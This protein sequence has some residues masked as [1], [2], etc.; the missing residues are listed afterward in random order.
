M[1]EKTV[2]R[3]PEMIKSTK[4]FCDCEFKWKFTE[5]DAHGISMGKT[6]PAYPTEVKTVYPKQ[7]FTAEN[8]ARIP[9]KQVLRTYKVLFERDSQAK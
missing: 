5:H 4:E 6:I 1:R 7:K 2:L 3:K 9:C 8:A